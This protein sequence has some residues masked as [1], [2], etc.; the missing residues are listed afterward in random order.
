M[1]EL[2]MK[3]NDKENYRF[4]LGRTNYCDRGKVADLCS[5]ESEDQLQK[6]KYMGEL[7]L[8]GYGFFRRCLEEV[9]ENE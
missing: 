6:C 1:I 9:A 8:I 3:C 5:F 7:E 2:E 4:K